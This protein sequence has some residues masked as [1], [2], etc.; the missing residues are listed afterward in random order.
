MNPGLEEQD[1]AEGVE[2]PARALFAAELG[3][4]IKDCR[5]K[6][7]LTAATLSETIATSSARLY[8]WEN[9]KGIPDLPGFV[10]LCEALGTSPND[11]LSFKEEEQED[12]IPTELVIEALMRNNELIQA[13]LLALREDVE[14]LKGRPKINRG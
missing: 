4:R 14:R 10:R 2:K 11:L 1:E 3:K 5:K 8:A 6:Q 13:D 12:R 7:G 9:G